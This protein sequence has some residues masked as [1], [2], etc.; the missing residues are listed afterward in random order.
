MGAKFAP[1]WAIAHSRDFSSFTHTFA[2]MT[3]S[4]DWFFRFLLLT[5]HVKHFVS[6]GSWV[7]SFLDRGLLSSQKT[8]R[9]LHIHLQAWPS[10]RIGCSRLLPLTLCVKHFL[11]E[12]AHGCELCSAVGRHSIGRLF[13]F[14]TSVCRSDLLE[15]SSRRFLHLLGVLSFS[16]AVARGC[17]VF[18]IVGPYQV[19][20]LFAFYTLV[21][22]CAFFKEQFIEAFA[23]RL[24]C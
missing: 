24:V 6:S 14:Y 23:A 10:W 9:C 20:R 19:R 4:K 2:G 3:F 12:P 22:R 18:S 21:R 1:L 5:W 15:T 7:Q 13:V 8:L 11:R 16:R 17:K